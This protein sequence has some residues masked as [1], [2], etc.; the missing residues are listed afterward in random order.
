M[1]KAMLVDDEILTIN[2]LKNIIDW[3]RYGIEI[4]ATASDG[5]EALE[6]YRLLL[7]DI[8]ITDIKMP[9][10]GGLE[11]IRMVRA[12]NPDV[13]FVFISAY[14]DFNYVKEAIQ[15]GGA[16][17]I[18]KPVDEAELEQ[19]LQ[20]IVTRISDKSI[21]KKLVAKDEQQKK[22]TVLRDYMRTG[23]RAEEALRIFSG[24]NKA[25]AL[26]SVV[27]I[28][29]NE[30]TMNDYAILNSLAGEQMHYILDRMQ[31][32]IERT[33]A[34][35]PFEYDG[36]AWMV[37]LFSD[38]V[39][40]TVSVSEG[41]LRF[42][43]EECKTNVRIS[44]SR[45]AR[46]GAAL[47]ELYAQ[48]QQYAKYSLYVDQSGI[49]GYGYNCNEEEF[50]KIK[51]Q[52]LSSN[53]KEA[54]HQHNNVEVKRILNSV[55]RMSENI[56]PQYLGDIYEFCFR[57][58]LGIRDV[59]SLSGKQGEETE[60]LGISYGEMIGIPSLEQLKEFMMEAVKVLSSP[61][62][63]ENKKYS[64]L[65]EKGIAFLEEHYNRNLSLEEICDYLS[66]SKNYFSYL[67]KRETGVSLWAFLTEI[68][69]NRAKAFLEH[70][71]WKSYE[72]AYHVG[73]DNPSYF[74]KLFKKYTGETPNEYRMNRKKESGDD[75][76]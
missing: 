70:T 4:E 38:T 24:Y 5:V 65:V 73:Y 14:A 9:N 40:K 41:L 16:N 75:E 76:K 60:A 67:F 66:V 20:G 23:R 32:M 37:I 17:Y 11:F 56:N 62:R 57:T 46:R 64:D 50:D 22:K 55:F 59:L 18:L 43:R 45:L 29:P 6:K 10:L 27:S 31:K 42:F 68:R 63:M 8:V 12:V 69:I 25:N 30:K 52:A 34:C 74:N 58:I 72:I 35:V 28:I 51:L 33:C 49:L 54:L 61:G 2:M 53:M 7:P 36:I 21:V 71:R 13:E 15:L 26:F 19:T 1:L 48:V 47:P 39:Q 44:F 3:S